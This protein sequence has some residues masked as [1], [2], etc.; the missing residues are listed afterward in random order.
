MTDGISI[1]IGVIA[2]IVI[3]LALSCF[4][5]IFSLWS[6]IQETGEQGIQGIDGFQGGP[7]TQGSSGITWLRTYSMTVDP[8]S[9]S[10]VATLGADS[11]GNVIQTKD[12]AGTYFTLSSSMTNPHSLSFIYI[13]LGTDPNMYVPGASFAIDTS[14]MNYPIFL[15]TLPTPDGYFWNY[16]CLSNL[17]RNCSVATGELD[18]YIL[19]GGYVYIF[20]YMGDL[21]NNTGILGVPYPQ[22]SSPNVLVKMLY[23]ASYNDNDYFPPTPLS[24]KETMKYIDEYKMIKMKEKEKEEKKRRR[25]G[26]RRRVE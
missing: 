26:G 15:S 21:N 7:G 16:Y 6:R 20:S 5:Y 8:G 2:M 24:M 22:I 17:N 25:R 11:D 19:D 3:S 9:T 13:R 12:I 1:T 10:T 4:I 14:G 18:G 23:Y